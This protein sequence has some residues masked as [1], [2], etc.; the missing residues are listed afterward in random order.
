MPRG[1]FDQLCET[2][3]NDVGEKAFKSEQYLED[4]KT[5]LVGTPIERKMYMAHLK[6]GSDYLC[7]EVK[8]ALALRMLAG[9]SYLDLSLIFDV[10][11]T[12]THRV[13]KHVVKKW[14]NNSDAVA[15]LNGTSYLND[16]DEMSRVASQFAI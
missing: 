6:H 3:K 4:L 7:G 11:S 8:L 1:C 9:G 5:G 15:D 10:Y 2:I 14:I 13:L 16:L 12:S